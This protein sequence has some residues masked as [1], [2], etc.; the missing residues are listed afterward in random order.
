MPSLACRYTCRQDTVYRKEK[1]ADDEG[2]GEELLM[3]PVGQGPLEMTHRA[4]GDTGH[5]PA[6]T[7]RVSRST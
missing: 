3:T 2:G 1:K 4:H 5:S 6:Q 7:A